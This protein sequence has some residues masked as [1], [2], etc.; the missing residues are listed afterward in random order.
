MSI[1][2]YI[3]LFSIQ[4][5]CLGDLILF[6]YFSGTVQKNNYYKQLGSRAIYKYEYSE[7]FIYH[8]SPGFI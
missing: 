2:Q 4:L 3:Y 6:H 1:N 5:I 7:V 8:S